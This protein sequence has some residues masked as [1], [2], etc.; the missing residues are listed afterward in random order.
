MIS[1]EGDGAAADMRQHNGGDGFVV[2]GELALRRPLDEGNLDDDL[3]THPVRP[4]ARQSDGLCKRGGW[5]LERIEPCAKI[6]QQPG[7]KAR[8]D[9]SGEDEVFLF[10]VADEQRAQTDARA[11]RI[12][13]PSYHELLRGLALH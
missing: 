3:G 4:N 6:E 13:K 8:T 5:D 1:F 9:L 7:V 11:L 2:G 12:G 10:E